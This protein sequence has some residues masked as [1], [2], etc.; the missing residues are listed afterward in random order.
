ML[1]AQANP[2]AS[3]ALI[4]LFILA[5]SAVVLAIGLCFNSVILRAAAK[6]FAGIE[7]E[8]GNAF[9]TSALITLVGA[10]QAVLFRLMLFGNF[11][12]RHEVDPTGLWGF[13]LVFCLQALVIGV[14]LE[15]SFLRACLVFLGF[16]VVGL[17][18]VASIILVIL[19]FVWMLV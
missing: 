15:L 4:L 19:L 17:C 5:F 14:R 10:I 3:S 12:R 16:Y 9:M 7:V 11:P 18:V 8:F 13:P 1:L 6:W 2:N